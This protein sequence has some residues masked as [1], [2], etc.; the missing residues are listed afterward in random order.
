MTILGAL[1]ISLLA[2]ATVSTIKQ[3]KKTVEETKAQETQVV[4][5]TTNNSNQ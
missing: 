5:E 4:E 1:L 3:N 2:S